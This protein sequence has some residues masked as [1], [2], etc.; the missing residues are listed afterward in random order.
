ML[1]CTFVVPLSSY[2]IRKHLTV[3]CRYF[4]SDSAL[5]AVC[6][7]A[8]FIAIILH[9]NYPT[10]PLHGQPQADGLWYPATVTAI[11]TPLPPKPREITPLSK[12]TPAPT[13]DG[14]ND[15]D[16]EGATGSHD[17][18]KKVLSSDNCGLKDE[19]EEKKKEREPQ[20]QLLEVSFLGYG[21]S[22][23]VPRGWVREIVT[24]E[25]LRWCLDNGVAPATILRAPTETAGD[26]HGDDGDGDTV[27][28]QAVGVEDAVVAECSPGFA[29]P[30]DLLTSNSG[31]RSKLGQGVGKAG[32]KKGTG[33]GKGKQAGTVGNKGNKN[34]N[35][36][37]LKNGKNKNKT[38]KRNGNDTGAQT[39]LEKAEEEE[40]FLMRCV[41]RSKS[42]Y[43]HVPSKYWGQRY[44]YFS[45]FDEGITLDEE[46]WYSVT[47][48]AIALHI[49]E[50]VC[51]D[52]LVDPFV[53]CGGNAVQFALVCHLVFAID[54][55]PV[56]L[57]HAR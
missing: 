8:I 1:C 36:S 45:R 56:K 48:E 6:S 53:G 41:S 32:G 5:A 50:R 34:K 9:Y 40:R 35:K 28:C 27:T 7:K 21:E 44:R 17:G 46:G 3:Y 20:E 30:K 22:S 10:F 39:C 42:P 47:P 25:V 43:P 29:L 23:K 54:L 37:N 15:I 2:P 19:N 38:K 57:E 16:G 24:P 33:K 31:N 49:A 55:D 18:E 14:V 26:C 13:R 52:V 51:C 12:S 4:V 11:H